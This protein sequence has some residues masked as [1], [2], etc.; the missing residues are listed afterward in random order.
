MKKDFFTDHIDEFRY[1]GTP[2]REQELRIPF[3]QK[4][5][6]V[7]VALVLIAIT[8]ATAQIQSIYGFSKWQPVDFLMEDTV[9]GINWTEAGT[10][11]NNPW[12]TCLM[13]AE[14][15]HISSGTYFTVRGY[16]AG[17]GNAAYTEATSGNVWKARF[18]P[19]YEGQWAVLAE[20]HYGSNINIQ[21]PVVGPVLHSQYAT[22]TFLVTST[23]NGQSDFDLHGPIYYRPDRHYP[24]HMDG[25]PYR[26]TYSSDSRENRLA[27]DGFEDLSAMNDGKDDGNFSNY[28]NHFQDTL[29]TWYAHIPSWDNVR[30][31]FGEARYLADTAG[32]NGI[33]FLLNNA[34]GGDDENV[35]PW[36]NWC[37]PAND[38]D[39]PNQ[40]NFSIKKL[41]RWQDYLDYLRRVGYGFVIDFKLWET[42]NDRKF[43]QNSRLLYLHVTGAAIWNWYPGTYLNMGEEND[44]PTE[45]INGIDTVKKYMQ[46]LEDNWQYNSIHP[47]LIGAHTYP[48]NTARNKMYNPLKDFSPFTGPSL[49]LGNITQTPQDVRRWIDYSNASS[50]KWLVSTDE[51]GPWQHGVPTD[52]TWPGYVNPGYTQNA[53][54]QH[55]VWE[56]F[57]C[58]AWR[59]SFYYGYQQ[60]PDDLDDDVDQ[61]SRKYIWQRS[62]LTRPFF[63]QI[64]YAEM[65]Y[66]GDSLCGDNDHHVLASSD[67]LYA[68]Y[69]INDNNDPFKIKLP[70]GNSWMIAHY[71]PYTGQW[72]V[73]STFGPFTYAKDANGFT[74]IP[75]T[76]P[77]DIAALIIKLTPPALPVFFVDVWSTIDK[78]GPTISWQV[79]DEVGVRYYEIMYQT[80]DGEWGRIDTV[81]ATGTPIYSYYHITTN[82]GFY[83]I[84]SLDY[85]GTRTV[86]DIIEITKTSQ[87]RSIEV[88]GTTYEVFVNSPDPYLIDDSGRLVNFGENVPS[89]YYYLVRHPLKTV[90]ILKD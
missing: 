10:G 39:H 16:Y 80:G 76:G 63:E 64:P 78:F 79:D 59:T 43:N 3:G 27:Y 56:S 83:Q 67:T 54:M 50:R 42:E 36:I 62:A 65:V 22:D 41:E 5:W 73:P 71:D 15:K 77:T 4:F 68:Y 82:P 23:T 49:Q 51:N 87:F 25:T 89:G 2:V 6:A 69:N 88:F 20:F 38:T 90:K 48:N 85:N 61:R 70:P 72:G 30:G 24:Y 47:P 26:I 52:P 19:P 14:F 21:R 46:V 29:S 45:Y 74:I 13:V 34:S 58:Q 12:V 8:T 60:N 84:I 35:F 1:V 66:G 17:D 44:W 53:I 57:F 86:S 55:W 32:A 28:S 40:Y 18:T 75:W 37:N 81:S 33:S 7:L 31:L 11:P 9:T